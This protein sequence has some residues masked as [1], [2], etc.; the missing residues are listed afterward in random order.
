M[1]RMRT[2]LRPSLSVKLSTALPRRDVED[3][4]FFADG[5]DDVE[6]L[7]VVRQRQLRRRAGHDVDACRVIFSVASSMTKILFGQPPM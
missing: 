3:L 6:V 7:L 1:L 5:V 2:F 4:D